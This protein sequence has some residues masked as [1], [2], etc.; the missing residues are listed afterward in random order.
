MEVSTVVHLSLR[1]IVN[2]RPFEKHVVS[3]VKE[4]PQKLLKSLS[5]CDS[6]ETI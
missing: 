1:F 3:I 5:S 4:R 6:E 2:A